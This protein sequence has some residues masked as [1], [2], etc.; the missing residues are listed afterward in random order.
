MCE[1]VTLGYGYEEWQSRET[2]RLGGLVPGSNTSAIPD[3]VETLLE[4]GEP[5]DAWIMRLA[6]RGDCYRLA[7]RIR[8]D[9][10][11]PGE[12]FL[13]EYVWSRRDAVGLIRTRR[14]DLLEG[15]LAGY[16]LVHTGI[17]RDNTQENVFPHRTEWPPDAELESDQVLVFFWHDGE[18]LYLLRREIPLSPDP[19]YMRRLTDTRSWFDSLP[20]GTAEIEFAEEDRATLVL[21][22][23]LRTPEAASIWIRVD[24]TSGFVYLGAGKVFRVDDLVWESDIPI[25]AVC[26]AIAS[27]GLREEIKLWRGRKTGADAALRVKGES[28]PITMG[29]TYSLRRA[30]ARLLLG[31]VFGGKEKRSRRYPPY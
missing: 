23:P 31:S 7:E 30:I 24:K 5:F 9:T 14:P 15:L 25:G 1:V 17:V 18:P 28:E 4:E 8:S 11:R 19:K 22:H 21:I 29:E 27:G 10:L 20:E 12:N 6:E 13:A 2:W 3:L 26:R 16:A